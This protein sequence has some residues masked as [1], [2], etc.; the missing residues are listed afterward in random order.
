MR[1]FRWFGWW[2]LTIAL[3]F[4][5]LAA[6]RALVG[7]KLWLIGL[8]LVIAAGFGV[9]AWFEFRAQNRRE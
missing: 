3:G 2:Y 9:L 1:R 7:E 8:R 5:L 4:V 6:N